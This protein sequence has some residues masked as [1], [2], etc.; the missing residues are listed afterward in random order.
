MYETYSIDRISSIDILNT[1]I[2]K[3]HFT[4]I[5]ELPS[6][7]ASYV[8]TPLPILL[9]KSSSYCRRWILVIRTGRESVST[10]SDIDDFT[11]NP[12]IRSWIG[13]SPK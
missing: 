5:D 10:N 8:H 6:L 9:T 4:G 13:I 7:Y 11:S 12:S 2:A 1:A 3:E